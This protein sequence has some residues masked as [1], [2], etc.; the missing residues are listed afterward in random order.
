MINPEMATVIMIIFIAV[1]GVGVPV[2]N[3]R[4]PKYISYRWCVIVVVL[5]LMLGAVLD[6]SAL[7]DETR[8]TLLIGSLIIVGA[9][10]ALRTFEKSAANG[11]LAGTRIEVKKGDTSA[12]LSTEE[13][14]K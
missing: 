4:A 14:K 6:F 7:S 8:R 3:K 2:L 13:T 11:W 5:A 1:F 10:V 9:Y 12:T